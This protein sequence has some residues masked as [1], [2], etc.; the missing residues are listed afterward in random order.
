MTEAILWSRTDD[1]V[2]AIES[3]N[4]ASPCYMM[5]ERVPDRWLTAEEKK[6]GFQVNRFAERE[7]FNDWERGR[8]FCAA[9]ELRW[10]TLEGAFQAVYAGVQTALPGF[11]R[12]TALH[13]EDTVVEERSYPLWGNRVPEDQLDT[14]G[15]E[16]LPGQQPFIEF[17][18]PRV[19]HY[20]VSERAQRVRLRVREYM[21]PSSGERCYYRFC[22]LEE[23]R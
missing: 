14:V 13:L 9:F 12:A 19:L 5:L 6:T 18:V 2:P 10:E 22:G 21:D 23:V 20:P 3:L 16:K 4:P 15:A 11:E 8:I 7:R 17:Q 1:L